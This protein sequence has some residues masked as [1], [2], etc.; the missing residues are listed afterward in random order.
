[1]LPQGNHSWLTLAGLLIALGWLIWF[2]WRYAWWRRTLPYHLPRILMYHMIAPPRRGSRYNGMRV[3]P[4]QFERQVR[5]L[6]NKGWH[7]YT[8]SELVELGTHV[9]PRSVAITFDD[10]YADNLMEALPVLQKYQ[11][12]ATVYVLAGEKIEDWSSQKNKA[13]DSGELLSEPRM[14]VSQ[15]RQ[16]LAS[17]LIEIGSHTLT[18]ANLLKLNV[19]ETMKE[20]VE[21]K[22][23]LEVELGVEIRSFAYPFG[24]FKVGD[25]ARVKEAG[26]R[27]AVTT[28]RGVMDPADLAPY[29]LPRLKVSGKEGMLAFMNRM[30]TGWRGANK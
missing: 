17:G 23:R 16:L 5:W 22:Q 24:Y 26:Y 28:E 9:K 2:S 13:H 10:G 30:R 27:S 21:S 8:V 14:S 12:K 7:F 6:R 18:H 25:E 4:H 29:Q 3:S 20:L 11:A 15:Q 19:N 1:M